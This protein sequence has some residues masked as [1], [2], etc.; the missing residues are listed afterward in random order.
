MG[1]APKGAGFAIAHKSISRQHLL[2]EI[3]QVK[4]GDSSRPE[5][6]SG[7][8]LE[9]LGS[10]QGTFVDGVSIPK[11]Q[12]QVLNGSDYYEV[13]LGTFA[14]V[15]RIHWQPV[16]LTF[17]FTGKEVRNNEIGKFTER[18]ESL[19]IK[20]VL[21]Y[22]R[23]KTTHVVAKKRNTS[24]GLQ[25]LINGKY[26]VDHTFVDAIEAAAKAPNEGE[27]QLELDYDGN[28]PKEVAHLPPKGQ[29][30]TER[31]SEAYAPDQSRQDIFDGYTFIFYD[32]A[33][34]D[35]LLAPI[36]N[37][38][39]KALLKEVKRNETTPDEFVLYVKGIAGEKG[40]GEF[41]DGS[42]GKG[43]VVVKFHPLKNGEWYVDFA[44]RVALRLDQRLIEQ[45]EFLDAI[46]NNNASV[47]RRPLEVEISSTAA[48]ASTA[49]Q[50]PT[51]T[52]IKPSSTPQEAT[53]AMP[54]PASRRGRARRTVTSRFKGFDDEFA[55]LKEDGSQKMD[56]DL[57][58][59]SQTS[60]EAF[61]T[62]RSQLPESQTQNSNKRPREEIP[63]SDDYDEDVLDQLAPAAAKLKR[64]RL[65]DGRAPEPAP[66]PQPVPKQ[67]KVSKK[68]IDILEVTKKKREEQ[69]QRA[70]EEAEKL[71]HA[72]EG[73]NTSVIRNAITVT[74]MPVH[75]TMPRPGQDQDENSRWDERWNGRANFKKFR[76]K[77][78]AGQANGLLMNKVIVP[79]KLARKNEWA[80][81]DYWLEGEQGSQGVVRDGPPRPPR[82]RVIDSFGVSQSESQAQ[83]PPP[84]AAAAAAARRGTRERTIPQPDPT[85]EPEPEPEAIPETIPQSQSRSQRQTRQTYDIESD[86]DD[87]P[88]RPQPRR[89][90]RKASV[91]PTPSQRTTRGQSQAASQGDSQA[92]AT[93]GSQATNKR[94]GSVLAKAG[95][96]KRAKSAA[97]P[98]II[99]NDEPEDDGGLGFKFGRGRK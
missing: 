31:P 20:V 60:G 4:P 61:A 92:P 28:W 23:D 94:P 11:D 57:P 46:L 96:A 64:L 73:L 6:R 88:I 2:L 7:V 81:E 62:A 56:I 1:R 78:Q 51:Q 72:M 45:S 87:M 95:P 53:S 68:Q 36:T 29:E 69:D 43:V 40:I 9:H 63:P 41:E 5:K 27:A 86:E 34:F 76:K 24:K 67:K 37:G 22:V 33:Q 17:S 19:D 30:Q 39:G 18:L 21:D 12:R 70:Q 50:P 3:G 25:A 99:E 90:A 35:N 59:Q 83:Q 16:V 48:P 85:P 15:F 14:E 91:E 71:S 93:R 42:E 58:P 65:A 54:A 47:L 38:K 77:G 97:Q 84:R 66:E 75:R 32:Q 55:D 80:R 52:A 8:I 44:N 98:I 89:T 79:L 49:P 13:K 74:T 10:K 82:Q 26:I